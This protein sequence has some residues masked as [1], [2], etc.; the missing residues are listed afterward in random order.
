MPWMTGTAVNPILRAAHLA[1]TKER[2]HVTLCVPWV[3]PE[4]QPC[5]F[6]HDRFEDSKEQERCMR[7]WARD[8][9]GF[10]PRIDIKF[11]A[12]RYWASIGS[13][14]ASEDL[15]EC[16]DER[17]VAVLEEPERSPSTLPGSTQD[18]TG[19]P[20]SPSSSASSTQTTSHTVALTPR[21]GAW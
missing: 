21:F 7:R 18:T 17:D 4:D 15:T 9:L 13:I 3:P 5:I 1:R 12:A 6:A 8:N 10:W 19:A 11:Y 2:H 14:V 16:V 20:A